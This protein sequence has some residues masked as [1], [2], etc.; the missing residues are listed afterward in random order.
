[1]LKIKIIYF[2]LCLIFG[3]YEQNDETLYDIKWD[4]PHILP[5]I[6]SKNDVVVMRTPHNE[7][8]NCLIDEMR[9]FENKSEIKHES[10][11]TYMSKLFIQPICSFKIES[12]WIYEICHGKFFM[13]YHEEKIGNKIDKQEYIL[14]YF[15]K[16]LIYQ[17]DDHIHIIKTQPE[18]IKITLLSSLDSYTK[19]EP[20]NT[21]I[22]YRIPT[23]KISHIDAFA[24][25]ANISD[26]INTFIVNTAMNLESSSKTYLKIQLE[27]GTFCQLRNGNRSTAVYYFCDPKGVNQIHYFSEVATCDYKLFIA[28]PLLCDHPQFSIKAK[29]SPVY[30]YNVAKYAEGLGKKDKVEDHLR[31][32]NSNGSNRMKPKALLDMERNDFQHYINSQISKMPGTVQSEPTPRPTDFVEDSLI[33]RKIN[34]PPK[35]SSYEKL[36]MASKEKGELVHVNHDVDREDHASSI[37]LEVSSKLLS[38]RQENFYKSVVTSKSHVLAS[39]KVERDFV[40]GQYCLRGGGL[41]WWKYEFCLWKHLIQYH[42]E[43]KRESSSADAIESDDDDSEPDWSEEG[44]AKKTRIDNKKKMGDS[45]IV[46]TNVTLGKWN[47]ATHLAWVEREKLKI[48]GKTSSGLIPPEQKRTSVTYYYSGGDYCDEVKSPRNATIKLRCIVKKDNP[49]YISMYLSEISI[50]NYVFSVDSP[51]ICSLLDKI[52]EYGFL[53]KADRKRIPPEA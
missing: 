20:L 12:F 37:D 11:I 51:I 34:K 31:D 1:M 52:D 10:P 25:Y 36:K 39:T 50:C 15:P 8:Y 17:S 18:E 47:H 49:N 35:F 33:T 2:L 27:N 21:L 23:L 32:W 22:N 9:I 46:V 6:V 44:N 19:D 5:K 14:G 42:E 53:K 26:K 3:L 43:K 41:G 7:E 48:K 28:T 45:L 16:E 13:Q 30:C 38:S 40:R 24:S 29:I 4:I